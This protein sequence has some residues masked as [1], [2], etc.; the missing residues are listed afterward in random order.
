M[1]PALLKVLPYPD[2][3]LPEKVDGLAGLGGD[4]SVGLE[5]ADRSLE[6]LLCRRVA[7]GKTSIIGDLP[8]GG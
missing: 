4:R 2:E 8:T 7:N 6:N 5:P 3:S 1:I